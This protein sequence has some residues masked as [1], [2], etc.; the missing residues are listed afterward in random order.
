MVTPLTADWFG[1]DC[2]IWIKALADG[3]RHLKFFP[4]IHDDIRLNLLLTA[5]VMHSVLSA[6]WNMLLFTR[7]WVG[8]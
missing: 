6:H 4:W 1:L 7:N 8:H 2:D 5:I 3:G